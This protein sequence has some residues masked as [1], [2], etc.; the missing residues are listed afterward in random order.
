[1]IAHFCV[2]L[3]L[4]SRLEH[5]VKNKLVSTI[6]FVTREKCTITRVPWDAPD[7]ISP[8]NI[9]LIFSKYP[10]RSFRNGWNRDLDR[11]GWKSSIL[12]ALP[13]VNGWG[14]RMLDSKNVICS[15]LLL[16]RWR[17]SRWKIFDRLVMGRIAWVEQVKTGWLWLGGFAAFV[18]VKTGLWCAIKPDR[19]CISLNINSK[20]TH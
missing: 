17:W 13:L 15:R 8:V 7:F 19:F 10:I 2:Q 18:L 5:L 6:L 14:G 12:A 4:W 20:L 11:L 9:N 3:Q 1:M 16:W